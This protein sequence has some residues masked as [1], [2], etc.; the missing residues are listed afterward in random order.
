MSEPIPNRSRIDLSRVVPW[1]NA[2]SE[3]VPAYGVVQ[4]RDDRTTV[5]QARKPD[6]GEGLFFVNGPVPVAATKR[7]ESLLWSHPQWALIDGTVTVGDEIGPVADQWYMSSEGTGFRVLM[8]PVGGVG[9]VVMVGGGSGG[10]HRIW[11]TIESVDCFE[12][13]SKVLSVSAI[14][15]SGGC[16]TT[17]PGE[18][19]YGLIDISDVCSTLEFYTAEQLLGAVGSATYMYPRGA[20]YC[21][22][23][24]LVDDICGQPSCA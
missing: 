5:S 1:Q 4:L 6:A 13:G 2:D 22:P 9:K 21:E 14:Y 23:V 3:E 7:G 10:C 8:Q 20:E 15:Y 16:N 18:D 17:I 19:S 24:W 11:F 12:D